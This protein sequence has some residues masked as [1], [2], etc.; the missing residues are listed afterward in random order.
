MNLRAL[1]LFAAV[2][3]SCL[4]GEDAGKT[5]W[6]AMDYG[7]TLA[8]TLQVDKEYVLRALIVRL[9][10]QKQTY[11][12]Y[13]LETMRV[14]AVWTGGF[15]DW[16]GVVF[17]G[18][19]HE[20]PKPAGTMVMI[21]PL[22]PGWARNGSLEDPR[23]LVRAAYNVPKGASEMTREGQPMPSDWVHLNGHYLYDQ[24]VVLSYHR[25]WLRGARTAFGR[26]GSADHPDHHHQPD[27]HRAARAAGTRGHRLRAGHPGRRSGAGAR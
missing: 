21:N 16:H 4:A 20:Q 25:E 17:N 27:H 18:T 12:C 24:Q 9:D 6:G 22:G 19:H 7:P 14:A 11:L 26:R 13:D 23:P 10:P 8:C 2:A 3:C 5:K 15:I 1:V